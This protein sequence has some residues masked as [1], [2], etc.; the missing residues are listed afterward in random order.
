MVN[1]TAPSITAKPQSPSAN[2]T[3]SFNFTHSVGSYTFTCKV[4]AGS[5][6]TCASPNTLSTLSDASHTFTVQAVDADGF[7]VPTTAAYTW[8]VNTTAPSITAKPSTASANPNP[9]FAFS[10]GV[11]TSFQCQRDGGGYSV[12]TSA[13]AYSGLSDGSHSFDVKALDA[14]SVATSVASY[15][16][17]IDTSAPTITAKPSNPSAN[18][19][20]SFSFTHAQGSYT[21]KC[22]RDSGGFS[23]VHQPQVLQQPGG[24]G[25][26]V[27]R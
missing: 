10:H 1:T 23:R 12:C 21:F 4:D 18:A 26:P 27:R 7:P 9:S 3:P 13:Q 6:A 14:D 8:T 5:F 11:Y 2:K 19:S 24:R 20:P 15:A 17:T 16:W 22:Q 25:P